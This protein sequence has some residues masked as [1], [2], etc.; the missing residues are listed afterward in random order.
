MTAFWPHKDQK[1]LARFIDPGSINRLGPLPVNRLELEQE[2]D[3]RRQIVAAIYDQLVTKGIRYA[4]EMYTPQEDE[5]IIRDTDEILST[6]REGTCLDLAL[7]M[8][9]LLIGYELLPVVVVTEQHAFVL[10]SV[11]HGARDWRSLGR[12]EFEGFVDLVQGDDGR[13]TLL[14]LV[15]TS[16]YLAVECTGFAQSSVLPET[17]I[18][19]DGRQG[20]FLSFEQALKAGRRQLTDEGSDLVFAFDVASAHYDWNI[21]PEPTRRLE[22]VIEQLQD[23]LQ[24]FAF[25]G[26]QAVDQFNAMLD[27]E[28]SPFPGAAAFSLVEHRLFTGREAEITSVLAGVQRSRLVVVQGAPGVGKTSLV[29]A[30][31]GAELAAA[32]GLVIRV[33][34]YHQPGRAVAEGLTRAGVELPADSSLKDAIW[35]LRDWAGAEGKWDRAV[36]IILD[37]FERLFDQPSAQQAEVIL[38]IVEGLRVYEEARIIISI[39]EGAFGALHDPLHQMTEYSAIRLEDLTRDAAI[40]ALIDPLAELDGPVQLPDPSLAARIVDDLRGAGATVPPGDI[41]RIGFVLFTEARKR[42]AQRGHS[43]IDDDL[44]EEL[45]GRKQTL[46]RFLNGRL[47]ELP[48]GEREVAERVLRALASLDTDPTRPMWISHADLEKYLLERGGSISDLP[49]EVLAELTRLGVIVRRQVDQEQ[50]AFSSMAVADAAEVIAGNEPELVRR[51]RAL[52]RMAFRR[53]TYDSSEW[54]SAAQVRYAESHAG[55]QPTLS[56]AEA[57][58]LLR[59]AVGCR[60]D[61]R[62]WREALIGE[63]SDVLT[64]LEHQDE[65]APSLESDEAR[66]LGLHERDASDDVGPLAHRTSRVDDP[67]AVRTA[68]IALSVVPAYRPRLD[69]ALKSAGTDRRTATRLAWSALQEVGEPTATADLTGGDLLWIQLDTYRRRIARQAPL[70]LA[71]ILGTAG[72]L[73]AGLALARGLVARAVGGNASL[74]VVFYFTQGLIL[75]AAAGLG[76]AL[77]RAGTADGK[78]RWATAVSAGAALFFVAMLLL[79]EVNGLNLPKRW[80]M[81][82]TAALLGGLTASIV[83]TAWERQLVPTAVLALVTAATTGLA[84]LL[85]AEVHGKGAALSIAFSIRYFEDSLVDTSEWLAGNGAE[86]AFA[87]SATLGLLLAVGVAAGVWRARRIHEGAAEA[88]LATAAEQGRKT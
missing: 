34:D 50:Y 6:T 59:S 84:Q 37:Q 87:A 81:L 25:P 76:V 67:D 38:D 83:L 3:G 39:R 15:D 26:G 58:F 29:M 12:R 61:P 86:L 88:E 47:E 41:S 4:Y 18:E 72:G 70:F 5:Q 54:A 7:L 63:G 31:V 42:R 17:S 82:P 2:P 1:G 55:S 10:V 43:T 51:F 30:G 11:E 16:R 45:G 69:Y 8:S 36:V 65:A 74:E 49:S 35:G 44:Y 68:A 40:G 52:V 60:R 14:D 62:P 9:G 19:A 66:L 73:A 22:R 24:I 27:K 85:F 21:R 78:R 20:G 32:G 48:E 64:A 33:D 28:R 80:L 57:L 46:A 79:A 53:W 56:P 71:I 23:Q 75:G 77:V 13:K